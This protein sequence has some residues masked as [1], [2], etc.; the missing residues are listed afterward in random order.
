M[1]AIC[2]VWITHIPLYIRIFDF[3]IKTPDIKYMRVI[4]NE[5]DSNSQDYIACSRLL[6]L[7]K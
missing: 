3:K 2:K 1:Y 4:K 7:A 6:P 5:V